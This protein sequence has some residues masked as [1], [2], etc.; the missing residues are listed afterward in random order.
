M[1]R[2]VYRSAALADLDAIYDVIEPDSPRRAL[3]F[4]DAIRSRCRTLCDHTH[5]GPARDDLGIGIRV[6]PIRGRVIV[7][8]RVEANTVQ[9][10][11]VFYGGQDYE[12]ILRNEDVG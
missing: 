6:Y 7:A 8:Y 10:T 3:S 5:L 9:I 1:T 2:L 4:V 11:R 12:T